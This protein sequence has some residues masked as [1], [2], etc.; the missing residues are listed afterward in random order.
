MLAASILAGAL[1]VWGG[2]RLLGFYARPDAGRFEFLA[3]R[4]AAFLAA[5]A[6]ALYPPGGVVPPSGSEAGIPEYVDRYLGVVPARVRWLMRLLFL[7][8]EQATLLFAAPGS[9]GRRRFSSLRAEQQVGQPRP[10]DPDQDAGE[11]EQDDR[12][13]EVGLGEQQESG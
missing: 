13:A 1:L 2:L 10:R 11:G 5:A 7:L 9:G 6:D 4:E 8:V 12:A 3:P